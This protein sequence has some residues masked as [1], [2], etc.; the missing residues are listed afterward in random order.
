MRWFD[1]I[2]ESHNDGT[3]S[4]PAGSFSGLRVSITGLPSRELAL[5]VCEGLDDV[6]TDGLNTAMERDD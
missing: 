6:Y 5:S 1:S 2:I 4:I 3:F